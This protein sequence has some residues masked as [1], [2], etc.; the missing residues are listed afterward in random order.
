MGIKLTALQ[1]LIAA[2]EE[3]SLRGAARRLGVS[4]P[5]V[6][7]AMR[8]LERA[9][10]APVL[11]RSTAGVFPTA[12]G[13]VLL[14]HGRRA[15]RE[16]D[17]AQEQIDQL[18]GRMVGELGVG[19][20]PLAVMLLIPETMR[21]F[22]RDYP[23]IQLRVR[24]E[25]YMAQLTLLREGEVDVVVGPIPDNLPPGEF[26]VE[27]LMPIE[28]A[29]VVGKGNPLARARSLGQL[30][31]AR[32]VFTSL[33]GKSG[34]A[35]QLFDLHGLTPP[36]PAAVVNSTL[37]LL[38]LL[39]QGDYVGLMPMPIA[40]HPLAAQYMAVVPIKEGHLPLTLGAIV[41]RGALLKPALR[42]F[43]AHLHRAAL[44]VGKR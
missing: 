21:T 38:A 34:Y 28:M 33:T 20:V 37:A 14:E 43:V 41:R 1:T 26:E 24:E 7:K 9:V 5:A 32:W 42:H 16:L 6:T 36:M 40:T 27:A 44:Q 11:Q 30:V 18:G 4:Q 19:A 12:Q 39:T 15:M 13:K 25:L 29:V 10:G 2:V 8:E 23:D 17:D 22:G 3:G 31:A 35:R